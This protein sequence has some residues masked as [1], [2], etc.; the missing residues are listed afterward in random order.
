[1]GM[2]IERHKIHTLIIKMY[3][4]RQY[5]LQFVYLWSGEV[6]LT[7]VRGTLVGYC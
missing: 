4:G 3:R 2:A 7:T 5:M 6:K 1:M